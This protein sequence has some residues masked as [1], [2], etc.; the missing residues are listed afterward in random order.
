MYQGPFT[1]GSGAYLNSLAT[2]TAG[3][4][5]TL[6]SDSA[7][8]IVE[9][10]AAF[11]YFWD[12]YRLSPDTIWVNSQQALDIN[13]K[14]VA[15]GGT[16]LFRYNM[17]AGRPNIDIVAGAV[18][19]SI[20]N[21]VMNRSV[22]LQVHPWCPPGTVLFTSDTI[23]YPMSGVGSVSQMKMRRDY[24]Q[25]EWPLKTFKYEFGVYADGVLQI[26]FLPA[27]GAITNIA[28]G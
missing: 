11:Q 14:V 21:K 2:G 19:A 4:G 10:N 17:D 24:F 20:M 1:A 5:T 6:T 26:Y 13:S 15:G 25:T 9:F 28:A 23:P 8:G 3:T 27:Y 16:P 12:N 22:R 18:V 7:G